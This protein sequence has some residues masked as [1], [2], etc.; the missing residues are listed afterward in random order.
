MTD[1]CQ[2]VKGLLELFVVWKYP[3]MVCLVASNDTHIYDFFF[4]NFVLFHSLK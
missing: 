4:R 1:L 3:R 2:R